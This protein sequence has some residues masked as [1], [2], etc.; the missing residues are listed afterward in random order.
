LA[1]SLGQL[2]RHQAPPVVGP[3]AC[4]VGYDQVD[5]PIRIVMCLRRSLREAERADRERPRFE[6]EVARPVA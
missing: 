4:R 5:G 6:D 1:Q 3:P 2:R